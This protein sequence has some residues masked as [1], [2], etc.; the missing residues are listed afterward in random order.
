MFCIRTRLKTLRKNTTEVP[1]G[2]LRVAQ[3]AVLAKFRKLDFSPEGTAETRDAILDGFQSSLRDY[4]CCL[5]FPGTDVLGYFQPSL[6]DSRGDLPQPVLSSAHTS[7]TSCW[8][9]QC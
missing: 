9:L 8:T 2:R 7:M 4:S 6:R 3:D 5:Q 1:K